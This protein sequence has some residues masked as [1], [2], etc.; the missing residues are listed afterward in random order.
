M[1]S[2]SGCR[3]S[4]HDQLA[5]CSLTANGLPLVTK[6]V[7]MLKAKAVFFTVSISPI[8]TVYRPLEQNK[9]THRE[10][11]SQRIEQN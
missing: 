11:S 9:V 7:A 1:H 2:A 6:M 5:R 4:V 8:L 3:V 10:E